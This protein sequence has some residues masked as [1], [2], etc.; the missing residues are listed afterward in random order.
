MYICVLAR[1]YT[2][3][4]LSTKRNIVE[5]EHYIDMYTLISGVFALQTYQC[6]TTNNSLYK[7][8]R[9]QLMI[10]IKERTDTDEHCSIVF[11]SW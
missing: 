2:S 4:H 5:I 6:N 11:L 7:Q 3:T 9:S 1:M 10:E 8:L